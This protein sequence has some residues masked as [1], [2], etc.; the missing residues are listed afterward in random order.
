MQG[1]GKQDM[2]QDKLG[3]FIS[4]LKEADQ[5]ASRVKAQRAKHREIQD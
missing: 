1:S 4:E 3:S 5:T 2:K